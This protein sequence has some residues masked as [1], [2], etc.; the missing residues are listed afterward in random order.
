[1]GYHRTGVPGTS[2]LIF[3]FDTLVGLPVTPDGVQNVNVT[4]A[5][6]GIFQL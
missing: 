4:W 5:A 1:V 6:G 3:Y 2:E